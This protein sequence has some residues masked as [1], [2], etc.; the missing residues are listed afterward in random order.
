[1]IT[2][3]L[4]LLAIMLYGIRFSSY[5][6]DYITPESTNAIKGVFAVIILYSHLRGYIVLSDSI[7]D[8]AYLFAVKGFGQFMVAPFLFYSGFGIMES[9]RKKPQY[10]KHFPRNRILKT[11]LHFDIAI[12]AF[13]ALMTILGYRYPLVNYL[14]CWFGWKSIG[15]SNWFIFD[16]LALYSLTYIAYI[17]LKATANGLQAKHICLATSILSIA[18]WIF[19]RLSGKDT[20]WY[21]TILT[22]PLGMWYSLYRTPIESLLIRKKPSI[23]IL[24]GICTI[25][26]VWHYVFF[27]DPSGIGSCLFCMLV[28]CSSTKIRINNAILQWLGEHAFSIYIIQ[29]LP[30]NLFQFFGWNESPYLFALIS[31]PTVLVSAHLFNRLLAKADSIFGF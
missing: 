25:F 22:Y 31:I 13:L 1:M 16:I 8:Q 2:L 17:L 7:S 30:M 12:L 4:I 27:H 14:T 26:V 15:N 23:L 10:F 18:L 19:L 20:Y 29:R 6:S 9:T 5:H 21:D 11:L 3:F 24:A 28:V